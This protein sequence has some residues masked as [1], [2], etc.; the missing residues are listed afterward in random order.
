[1]NLPTS[2]K[3][4][5]KTIKIEFIEKEEADKK[6]IFGEYHHKTKTMILDKS[7][8]N[9]EIIDTT[10]HEIFH[11]LLDFYYVDLRAKDEEIA[12]SVLASGLCNILYQNQDLLEF[13]YKSLKKE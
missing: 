1:M 10:I 2:I 11:A 12:C 6:K 9:S 4:G 13:L 7:L 5:S 3:F 8:D